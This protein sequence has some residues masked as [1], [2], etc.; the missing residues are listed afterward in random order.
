MDRMIN[1]K[2]ARLHQKLSE[3]EQALTQ[4][5]RVLDEFRIWLRQLA[6]QERATHEIEQNPELVASLDRARE[7]VRESHLLNHQ[8]IFGEQI[9]RE[10]TS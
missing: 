9:R 8:D 4:I 1:Q 3:V 5:H 2:I 6:D 7:A 10:G